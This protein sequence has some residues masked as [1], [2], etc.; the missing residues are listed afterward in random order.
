MFN[1]DE[2]GRFKYTILIKYDSLIPYKEEEHMHFNIITPL[3]S[4]G[5]VL[6]VNVYGYVG[7]PYEIKKLKIYEENSNAKSDSHTNVKILSDTISWI[8]S[9]YP[10]ITQQPPK[11]IP[12]VIL[13]HY[14]S[15]LSLTALV[16]LADP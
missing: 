5:K 1:F 12:K 13:H 15:T 3:S 2:I 4:K 14:F 9:T 8:S 6:S 11:S 7:P 16:L 10:I